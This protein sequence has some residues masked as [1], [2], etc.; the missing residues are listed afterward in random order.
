MNYICEYKNSI[1]NILCNEIIKLFETQ[2]NKNEGLT[3]CGINKNIKD[4]TDYVIPKNDIKWKKIENFLYK[5]L[6]NKLNKYI[7]THSKNEYDT[8]NVK[9]KIFNQTIKLQNFMIQK[10]DKNKGKYIYHDD[11][12]SEDIGQRIITFI[13]YLNNVEEG[14]NTVFWENYK[15]KPEQGKLILFPSFWCYPHKG[16]LPLSSDKFIITGWLYTKY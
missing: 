4:T 15:I 1:P 13:W 12:H 8:E 11:F 5:E 3:I 2:D 14:G 16:E 6:L 7:K 10:Y 9:Y